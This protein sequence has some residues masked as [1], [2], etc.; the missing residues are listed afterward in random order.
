MLS[1]QKEIPSQL[2]TFEIEPGYQAHI[3]IQIAFIYSI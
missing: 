3:I 1:N 2:P